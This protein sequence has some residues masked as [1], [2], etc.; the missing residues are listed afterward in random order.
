[1]NWIQVTASKALLTEWIRKPG[2]K[3]VI[4][5]WSWKQLKGNS[6]ISGMLTG[7]WD[8]GKMSLTPP[9]HPDETPAFHPTSR[10]TFLGDL[11]CI[12]T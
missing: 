2:Y 1:M 4:N 12:V 7:H 11:F 8:C 6:C 5:L 3:V 10:K 9:P